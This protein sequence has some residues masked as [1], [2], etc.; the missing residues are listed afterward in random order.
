MK[1]IMI[2]VGHGGKDP[3][4]V[5]NGLTE[6]ELNLRVGLKIRDYLK[7]Y[8]VE[9]AMTRESDID[10][11]PI[12]RI[13]LVTSFNPDLCVSIHHNSADG[14]ARGA[15]VIHAYYD[16]YD[17]K[18]A[19]DILSRLKAAGMPSRRAFTRLNAE[20]KDWY[21]MI[22]SIWDSDTKA[23]IVE[24]GF[25][26][27]P[28]DAKL[29]KD[30]SFLAAEAGCISEAIIAYFGIGKKEVKADIKGDT[31]AWGDKYIERLRELGLINGE[32]KSGD[33]MIWAEFASVMVNLID[34]YNIK[35]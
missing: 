29:L 11:K 35:S 20:N 22:R 8:D 31:A 16:K 24:G 5:A 23:I 15:E 9:T 27:N 4:A 32:H 34:K 28:E 2:D 1:R 6:K 21:Y 26:D 12:D 33:N 17:D 14:K 10:L 30:E 18:L 3:G 7:G 19:E 13:M 25:L